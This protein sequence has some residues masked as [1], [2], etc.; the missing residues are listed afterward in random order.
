MYRAR[1]PAPTPESANRSLRWRRILL[2]LK[3]SNFKT[4][5][6]AI[7][8]VLQSHMDANGECWPSHVTVAREAGTTPETVS[9][10]L[11]QAVHQ[12]WLF[13]ER[14]PGPRAGYYY[15]YRA[16]VPPEHSH[17]MDMSKVDLRSTLE[18]SRLTA[19][20][21]GLDG[22][23]GY[24]LT[25]G[26]GN[27]VVNS[28]RNSGRPLDRPSSD[29][30]TALRSALPPIDQITQVHAV[31]DEKDQTMIGEFVTVSGG[32]AT[33]F[34]LRALPPEKQFE[35]VEKHRDKLPNPEGEL[36]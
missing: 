29:E 2:D 20:Q 8:L 7:L 21:H 11:K 31:L 24:G 16:A 22:S 6:V 1:S 10:K 23:P 33:V 3:P 19:D 14:R 15:L 27:S 13:R 18:R 4:T 5:T 12:G 30:P 9:R 17:L 26:Q 36:S 25:H 34:N 35:L 32:R 28:L